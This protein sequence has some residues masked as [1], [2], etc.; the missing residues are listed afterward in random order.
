LIFVPHG[1]EEKHEVSKLETGAT[2]GKK[3]GKAAPS[4]GYT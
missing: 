2:T 3:E 4:G 1:G